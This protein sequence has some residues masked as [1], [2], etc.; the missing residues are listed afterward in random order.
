MTGKSEV[1][2]GRDSPNDTG[3][4]SAWGKRDSTECGLS[5]KVLE[6]RFWITSGWPTIRALLLFDRMEWA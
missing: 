1:M 5:S 4:K 3:Q 2:P 6:A